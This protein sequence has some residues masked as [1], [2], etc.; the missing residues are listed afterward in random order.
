MFILH[1][2]L[3]VD[4]PFDHLPLIVINFTQMAVQI[5]FM[6]NCLFYINS[7]TVDLLFDH[8][9]LMHG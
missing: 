5:Y 1:K 2:L 3:T 7:L 9:P 6:N 8:L 4:V